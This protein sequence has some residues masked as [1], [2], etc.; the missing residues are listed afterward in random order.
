MTPIML[1]TEDELSEAVGHKLIAESGD[2]LIVSQ[3]F[4]RGGFGYLK[5][6]LHKF[7]AIAQHA[8]LMLLTDLDQSECAPSL[9]AAWL[10]DKVPPR[11]LFFRVAVR[12]TESWLLA[13]REAVAALLGLAVGRIPRAPDLLPDPK[14][15]L[16]KLANSSKKRQLKRDLLPEIGSTAKIGLGY[17]AVLCEFVRTQWSGERASHGSPSLARTRKCI[18]ELANSL[19]EPARHDF[20]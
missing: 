3:T 2:Y 17:N 9:I 18:N 16:L 5:T 10:K 12:E 20:T 15:E 14:A 7:F 4:R 8:P 6:N 19:Y 13:D 1:A 11:Q